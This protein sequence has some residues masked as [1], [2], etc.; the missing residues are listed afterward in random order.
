MAGRIL[1][2]REVQR[3]DHL[4][5]GLVER[6]KLRTFRLLPPQASAM[7]LGGTILIRPGHEDDDE[8]IAHE[9]VHVRQWSELGRVGF[10]VRY[11][12]AYIKNLLR[13]RKHMPA[14]RAIPLEIEARK[15][16]AAWRA[17]HP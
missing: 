12:G 14:Y 2:K 6:A 1:S 15:E 8:L 5:T 9:L 10:L 11:L 13:L 17:K 3:F 7:T 16:A 4:P